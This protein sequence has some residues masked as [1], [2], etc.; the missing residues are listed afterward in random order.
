[1][2]DYTNC[3]IDK[4]SIHQVGN[5]TNEEELNISKN[6]L[7]ISDSKVRELLFKFFLNPFGSP[8]FFSFTFTNKDSNQ[9]PYW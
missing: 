6:Q 3:N 2:I 5:K 7:D 1:M 9:Y 4:V 8:E